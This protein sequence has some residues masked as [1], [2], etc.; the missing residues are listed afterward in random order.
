MTGKVLYGGAA[1]NVR[2]APFGGMDEII[3]DAVE[4]TLEKADARVSAAIK[5]QVV[6]PS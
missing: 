2:I 4:T 1:R 5:A 6:P 3:A